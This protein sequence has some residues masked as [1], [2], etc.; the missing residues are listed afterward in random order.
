MIEATEFLGDLRTYGIRKDE[1]FDEPMID[2]FVKSQP[3]AICG[4]EPPSTVSHC[5]GRGRGGNNASSIFKM[6]KCI[7]CHIKWESMS[8]E[9]FEAWVFRTFGKRIKMRALVMLWAEKIAAY[10][11]QTI[12]EFTGDS[13]PSPRIKKPAQKPAS[14]FTKRCAALSDE[15]LAEA[16]IRLPETMKRI[17]NGIIGAVEKRKLKEYLNA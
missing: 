14:D 11:C 3:C 4:A 5:I 2:E 6:P 16:G 10:L 15:Q 12:R 8:V 17:H 7:F 1:R 13:K 9:E